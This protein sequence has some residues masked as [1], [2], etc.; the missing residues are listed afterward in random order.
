MN[1][2]MYRYDQDYGRM[3]SLSG[4][5]LADESDLAWFMGAEVW[6]HDV[7][8]KHSEVTI[9]FGEDTV[10]E[11]VVSEQTVAE[12]HAVLGKSIS[13]TTPYEFDYLIDEL[14]NEDDDE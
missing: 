5:F 4:V 7:L 9:C 3:G 2:K 8:G 6:A 14:K 13:G 11:I 1:M 12:L 10:K